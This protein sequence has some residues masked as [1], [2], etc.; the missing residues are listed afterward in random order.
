MAASPAVAEEEE[1]EEVAAEELEDELALEA[2]SL[3]TAAVGVFERVSGLSA[4]TSALCARID[5][6]AAAFASWNELI[7]KGQDALLGGGEAAGSDAG[8]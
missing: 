1:E 2:E 4:T 6:S 7:R 3:G 5:T 8:I